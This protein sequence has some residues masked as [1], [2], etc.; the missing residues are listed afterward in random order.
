MFNS[1]L[2][3]DIKGIILKAFRKQLTQK[4]RAEQKFDKKL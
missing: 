3:L 2:D 4:K 1:N